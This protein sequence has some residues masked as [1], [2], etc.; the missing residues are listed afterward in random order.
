MSTPSRTITFENPKDLA[1]FVAE[2]TRQGIAFTVE[3]FSGVWWVR[4]TG[5]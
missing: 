4:I 3:E 2:L 1:V 5:Y